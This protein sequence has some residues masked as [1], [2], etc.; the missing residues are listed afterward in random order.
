VL[1]PLRVNPA[2]LSLIWEICTF[3]LPV[4]VIVSVSVD[5]EPVFTFPKPKLVELKDRT[6]VCATPVPLSAIVAGELGALLTTLRPPVTAP[7][8]AGA[9]CTLKVLDCPAVR[10]IG[11]DKELVLKPLPETF[12][13]VTDSFPVPLLVN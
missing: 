10:V 13:C 8:D 3:A 6:K 12:T 5:E 11:N 2:P 9:N 4:L 7:A 1:A